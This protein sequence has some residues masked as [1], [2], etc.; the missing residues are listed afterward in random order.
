MTAHL[1]LFYKLR[2][3]IIIRNQDWPAKRYPDLTHLV[4]PLDKRFWRNLLEIRG[5]VLLYFNFFR[6]GNYYVNSIF[7]RFF[8]RIYQRVL[9]LKET[10]V[11]FKIFNNLQLMF[12]LLIH[13]KFICV[14]QIDFDLC[15]FAF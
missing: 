10:N 8:M 4:Y 7:F 2:I 6:T 5:Q 3:R 13:Q 11:L 9:K 12:I 14:L 1:F 15:S